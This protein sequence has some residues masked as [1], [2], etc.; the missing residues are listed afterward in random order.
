MLKGKQRLTPVVNEKGENILALRIQ[1]QH[2]SFIM[3]IIQITTKLEPEPNIG[4][5]A[6]RTQ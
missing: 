4:F 2:N 1:P 3:E 5:L 6:A